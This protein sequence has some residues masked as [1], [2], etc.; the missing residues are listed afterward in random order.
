MVTP[1]QGIA[2]LIW[3]TVPSSS[4]SMY[5]ILGWREK[6]LQQ[7]QDVF[8]SPW[9]ESRQHF[10]LHC[11]VVADLHSRCDPCQNQPF[12][13]VAK[14]ISM[15]SC[16]FVAILD[17]FL[18]IHFRKLRRPNLCVCSP[19]WTNY[20]IEIF[21]W[22]CSQSPIYLNSKVQG[23]HGRLPGVQWYWYWWIYLS[24][25]WNCNAELVDLQ[26]SLLPSAS[27]LALAV[28]LQVSLLPSASSLTAGGSCAMRCFWFLAGSILS[29]L[30]CG[31]HLQRK[32]FASC[33]LIHGHQSFWEDGFAIL[34]RT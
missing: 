27:S 25:S 15:A 7:S 8:S 3:C 2:W 33:S 32:S 22:I 31:L 18:V 16:R 10:L 28:D 21:C 23:L 19:T 30:C 17:S 5:E 29:L 24:C 14:P 20:K 12:G 11:V 1:T 4:A 34:I 6:H 26:V 9:P 13:F